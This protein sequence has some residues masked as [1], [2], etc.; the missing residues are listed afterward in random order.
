[1]KTYS[2]DLESTLCE[3]I[4]QF[5]EFVP[6]KVRQLSGNVEVELY[7]IVMELIELR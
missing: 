2:S 1:M 6:P 7:R 3:E 4:V 5:A